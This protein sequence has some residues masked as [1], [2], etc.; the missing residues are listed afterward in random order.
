[1]IKRVFA[2]QDLLAYSGNALTFGLQA[3]NFS[4]FRDDLFGG[5]SCYFHRKSLSAFS[6]EA[7]KT[8]YSKLD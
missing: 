2:D 7:V 8:L 5:V 6:K 1:M 3:F 4:E